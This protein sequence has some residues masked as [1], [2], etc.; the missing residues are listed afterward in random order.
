MNLGTLRA[1]IKVDADGAIKTLQGVKSGFDD[2]AK[3]ADKGIHKASSAFSSFAGTLGALGVADVIGT[4]SDKI[5]DL[6]IEAADSSDAL[7][8]FA[9][10]MDFAGFDTSTIEAVQK[11]MKQYADETVYD[12]G[13]IANAT[14]QLAANGVKDYD[15]LVEAAG[16]LNAVAGG[17]AD[18]FKSV[19]QVLTQTAG[20]GK[21]TTENWN[22]LA[23]AIPGASG[24]L[25]Q[26]MLDAGAYT[27]NFREAMEKGEITAEEFSAAIMNLGMEDAAQEA[28]KSTDTFEGAIGDLEATFVDA[29]MEIY[30]TIGK[31]NITGAIN[32]ISDAVKE[33]IPAIV[34]GVENCIDTLSKID[35]E[36][37]KTIASMTAFALGAGV[38]VKAIAKVVDVGKTAS[39]TIRVFARTLNTVGDATIGVVAHNEGLATS[40]KRA[41]EASKT[42]GAS[43]KAMSV[44][45]GLASTS[46]LALGGALATLVVGAIVQEIAEY[47]EHMKIAEGATTGLDDAVKMMEQTCSASNAGVQAYSSE[48][49]TLGETVWET[50]DRQA[51]LAKSIS[52]TWAGIGADSAIV[53]GYIAS[54]ER[55]G[56][57]GN[58]TAQEQAEL[59]MAVEG[60]ND[61]CG[62]SIEII[63]SVN[64]TLSESTDA[65]KANTEAWKLNIEAQAA[66]EQ[67]L[68]L[69][70]EQY[71]LE[72][73]LSEAQEKLK[74]AQDNLA[75]A[76]ANGSTETN[77]YLN[78]C[79]ALH[80]EID[81]LENSLASNQT[82]QDAMNQKYADTQLA[83]QGSAT[84]L[85]DYINSNTEF[86]TTLS[87]SGVDIDAFAT[88]LSELGFTTT[89]LATL[90]P[91][92]LLGLSTAYTGSFSDIKAKCEE[93]GIALPANMQTALD[94][95]I[96]KVNEKAPLMSNA[97]YIYKNGALMNFNPIT[98]E[99]TAITD[100][101]ATSAATELMNGRGE[102]Q[103]G[104]SALKDGAIYGIN[105]ITGKMEQ[106]G[107]DA[108]DNFASGVEDGEDDAETA[109]E[110]VADEAKTG[111]KSENDNASSWGSHLAQNFASGISSMAETVASTAS[112][113]ASRVKEIL[114][115]T[116]AE[117]GPLHEGGKGEAVWGAHLVQN[118]IAGM[119]SQIPQL[120]KAVE[121]MA[122]EVASPLGDMDI[123]VSF[124]MEN[125]REQFRMS[126]RF[127]RSEEK[128][129]SQ[130]KSIGATEN[131]ITVNN[132]S[133]KALTEKESAWQFKQTMRKMTLSY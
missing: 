116:V 31:E 37:V 70:K 106:I 131:N 78:E 93:L 14:A 50:V 13:T 17:N 15:R 124:S 29:F 48:I 28:A 108:S 54:I 91:E 109:G 67:A 114:G 90:A 51:Q 16:N 86:S 53:D 5:T 81:T 101:A 44:A 39:D 123:P 24:K 64:G 55:L 128:T 110:G 35:G 45:T 94:G 129:K 65:I 46:V 21:L 69:K 74:T 71:S 62:T 102:A 99:M 57:K 7:D 92:Q 49:Q 42:A 104:G 56:N 2:F 22:Q 105:P 98:G 100:E 19:A 77:K 80:T 82:A 112:S 72:V 9:S 79:S 121:A 122:N 30:D 33:S 38:A 63:D 59:K 52:E 3:V 87:T 76:Q 125:P 6:A 113:L 47:N 117:K 23:D 97:M 20:A 88:K 41:T 18:T 34:E 84:A 60:V 66:Q 132:Y 103:A 120:R 95:S 126:R 85:R 107:G 83:L 1:K 89:D 36:T 111:M 68:E 119:E 8:K 26:A 127:T 115:H 73:Q 118:F 96:A 4:I 43:M 75:T 27:G 32:A 133:P 12:L 61:V 58:L 130:D 10:T 11:S 40:Y 25:Q